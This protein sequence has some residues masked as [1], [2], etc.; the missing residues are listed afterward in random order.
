M[1]KHTKMIILALALAWSA[2]TVAAQD[3]GNTPQTEQPPPP[4]DG[5][6]GGPSPGEPGPGHHHH[7]PPPSPLF[8]AL[9]ANGDGV[10]DEQEMANAPA[11]LKKLDKN[12][13][14]V[15]TQDEL[16]P[17]PPPQ[18]QRGPHGPRG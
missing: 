12:G 1:K 4:H 15:L 17:P 9:D 18:G 7:P 10:I 13:D 2:F 3:A 5:G 16:R 11:A 14:G 8:L 6:P